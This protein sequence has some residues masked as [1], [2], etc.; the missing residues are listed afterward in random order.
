MEKEMAFEKKRRAREKEKK[1]KEKKEKE[2]KKRKKEKEKEKEKEK[3]KKKKKEKE[4]AK[5]RLL[6][7]I[8]MRSSSFRRG[9]TRTTMLRVTT[10]T[11]GLL[12]TTN[13][14]RN[15][16]DHHPSHLYPPPHLVPPTATP[17]IPIPTRTMSRQSHQTKS[18]MDTLPSN[19]NLQVYH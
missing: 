2:K 6:I 9:Q 17:V 18:T 10:L 8:L 12:M 14:S 19:P 1:E 3:K 5:V 15:A 4:K 13:Q 11:C 7:F 16:N